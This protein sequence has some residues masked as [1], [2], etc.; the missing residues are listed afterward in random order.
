MSGYSALNPERL[1]V[2]ESVMVANVESSY[3]GILGRVTKRIDRTY[4]VKLEERAFYAPP[5][6]FGRDELVVAP[7]GRRDFPR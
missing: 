2:T 5:M 4:W 3:Y 7:S 1:A 6:P